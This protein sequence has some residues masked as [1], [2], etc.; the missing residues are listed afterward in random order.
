MTESEMHI[1]HAAASDFQCN[2]LNPAQ[3]DAQ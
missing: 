2:I 3:A 1:L